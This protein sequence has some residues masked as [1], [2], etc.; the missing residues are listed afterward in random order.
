MMVWCQTGNKPLSE[1]MMSYF[2]DVL[3]CHS[4]PNWCMQCAIYW[5]NKLCWSS[6]HRFDVC[7]TSQEIYIG[8]MLCFVVMRYLKILPIYFM[9]TQLQYHNFVSSH[10]LKKCWICSELIVQRLIEILTK[11]RY[12]HEKK[13]WSCLL[14]NSHYLYSHKGELMDHQNLN[15]LE[16]LFKMRSIWHFTALDQLIS[17]CKSI[18]V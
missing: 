11:F 4:P 14:F 12:F 10:N 15:F 3:L 8:F 1:P 16:N 6:N 17:R 13:I 7:S 2:S 18:E 5:V 9:L